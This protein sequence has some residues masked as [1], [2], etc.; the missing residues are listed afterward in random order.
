MGSPYKFKPDKNPPPG[1]YDLEEA[2]NRTMPKAAIP[3]LNE[4][5]GKDKTI[6]VTPDGG[7]YEPIKPFG[8]S[9]KKM[10]LGGKYKWKPNGTPHPA[11]Y[12]P[13]DKLTKSSA[14]FT[15]ITGTP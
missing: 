2:W 4:K 5:V 12:K 6:E 14:Q 11:Y 3:K 10:T 9:E 15:K 1:A 7:F 13:S 8:H